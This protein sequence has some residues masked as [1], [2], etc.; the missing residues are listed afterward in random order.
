LLN[1]VD[2]VGGLG[3]CGRRLKS[4]FPHIDEL[5]R[6]ED[7]AGL[8]AA[9]ATAEAEDSNYLRVAIASALRSTKS[10]HALGVI[11]RLLE[12]P[13]WMVRIVA[14]KAA[15]DIGDPAAAA[16]LIIRLKVE[17]E[18]GLRSLAARALGQVGSREAVDALITWGL[19]DG[20]SVVRQS[21]ASALGTLQARDALDALCRALTDTSRVARSDAAVALV[22]IRDER[23]FPA[24]K[25]Y[26]ENASR[27][28]RWS[29]RLQLSVTGLTFP[30]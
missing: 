3:G 15:G 19:G 18:A 9:L 25:A 28:Q 16:P 1:C 26:W 10:R 8:C 22:R 5:K 17:N 27:T 11:I 6:R 2:M 23:A 24:L 7:V 21:A 14:I 29:I 20:R 30:E 13:D 4:R 12:D